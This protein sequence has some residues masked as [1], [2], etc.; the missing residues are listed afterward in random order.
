MWE[1]LPVNYIETVAQSDANPRTHQVLRMLCP[2]S[3][4]AESACQTKTKTRSLIGNSR[5]NISMAILTTTNSQLSPVINSWC[6]RWYCELQKIAQPIYSRVIYI[7]TYIQLISPV[8]FYNNHRPTD[9]PSGPNNPIEEVGGCQKCVVRDFHTPMYACFRR[10]FRPVVSTHSGSIRS[11]QLILTRHRIDPL[12]MNLTNI[13]MIVFPSI[14]LSSLW[15]LPS[16]SRW[17]RLAT[18]IYH[19]DISHTRFFVHFVRVLCVRMYAVAL[20][21]ML[22][23]S[24]S[25]HYKADDTSSH[26]P[27]ESQ[28]SILD[29]FQNKSG[30]ENLVFLRSSRGE[31]LKS[32][33]GRFSV[34]KIS[35]V[36]FTCYDIVRYLNSDLCKRI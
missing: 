12:D 4:W 16:S 19:S 26:C 2:L 1:Q 13:Q 8:S 34:P 7:H 21:A 5:G 28:N 18:T 11:T 35:A 30:R 17:A 32:G 9:L 6:C 15:S 3:K 31:Y 20:H 27:C 10:I 33:E 24:I 23:A 25:D 14:T 22:L 36:P 29:G